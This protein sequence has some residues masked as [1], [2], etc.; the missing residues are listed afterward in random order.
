MTVVRSRQILEIYWRWSL[1]DGLT[2][3]IWVKRKRNWSRVTPRFVSRAMGRM[4]LS[5]IGMGKMEQGREK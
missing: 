4:E 5:L 3:W 2:D 1:Q